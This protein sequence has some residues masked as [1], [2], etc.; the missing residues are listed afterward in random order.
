MSNPWLAASTFA[1]RA[2]HQQ[3]GG[4]VPE[5]PPVEASIS[6]TPEDGGPDP[7]TRGETDSAASAQEGPR[8][9]SA[10]GGIQHDDSVASDRSTATA[11]PKTPAPVTS[12]AAAPTE[13]YGSLEPSDATFGGPLRNKF[14]EA[15]KI[16][17]F[18]H[19]VAHIKELGED[20]RL[21]YLANEV[22]LTY[23]VRGS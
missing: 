11:S 21:D 13:T 15:A 3:E 14:V 9:N 12:G 22:L 19:R 18:N 8:P 1:N 4:D 16:I 10:G 6:K 23:Q 2:A 17:R 5:V 20:P 7:E